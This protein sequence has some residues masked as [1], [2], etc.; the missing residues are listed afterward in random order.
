[1]NNQ[2]MQYI[3]RFQVRLFSWMNERLQ[4]DVSGSVAMIVT[5]VNKNQL[6]H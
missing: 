5:S 6:V 3:V 4:S 2:E 1:M